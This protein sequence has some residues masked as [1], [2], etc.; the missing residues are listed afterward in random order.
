MLATYEQYMKHHKQ[1]RTTKFIEVGSNSVDMSEV[2]VDGLVKW[3]TEFQEKHTGKDLI[4]RTW[5]DDDSYQSTGEIYNDIGYYDLEPIE[6]YNTR[7]R[8]LY[9]RYVEFYNRTEE[10][11]KEKEIKQLEERL[12]ELRGDFCK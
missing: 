10:S 5:S 6:E 1:T 11:D 12:A 4:L 3:L 8:E 7:C 2:R 9:N